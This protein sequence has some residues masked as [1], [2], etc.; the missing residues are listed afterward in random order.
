M[1]PEASILG[2]D[3]FFSPTFHF[4]Y[5]KYNNHN[6]KFANYSNY[7]EFTV[8]QNLIEAKLPIFDGVSAD[9]FNNK[10]VFDCIKDSKIP[11]NFNESLLLYSSYF[12]SFKESYLKSYN[13]DI[14]T[15]PSKI[16]IY[17][18]FYPVNIHFN[19][20]DRGL[21][22]NPFKIPLLNTCILLTSGA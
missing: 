14:I 10:T 11:K 8:K 3:R 9:E 1:K 19:L 6:L 16:G 13:N 22:I 15:A 18:L 5:L 2:F 17:E 20:Y 7:L 12:S 21:L 4:T